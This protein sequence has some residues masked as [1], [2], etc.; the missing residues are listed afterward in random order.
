[1]STDYSKRG[2]AYYIHF[3]T[4]G[5][6]ELFLS[7][8]NFDVGH[9]CC[10]GKG[11]HLIGINSNKEIQKLETQFYEKYEKKRKIFSRTTTEIS[12]TFECP[13]CFETLKSCDKYEMI[14]N[15][16]VCKSCVNS[17]KISNIVNDSCPICRR[18]L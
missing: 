18:S 14:C 8:Y 4:I 9:K 16:D 11:A 15:H 7:E 10:G 13:V 5:Q 2:D 17:I 6:L 3:K 12:K 1:M